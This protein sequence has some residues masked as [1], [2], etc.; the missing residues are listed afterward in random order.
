MTDDIDCIAVLRQV[1]ALV[2]PPH[3]WKIA[4]QLTYRI[5]IQSE[6]NQAGST[7]FSDKVY[8]CAI[9]RINNT[10]LNSKREIKVC[11][12]AFYWGTSSIVK[13][14]SIVNAAGTKS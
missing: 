5:S 9:R 7:L 4:Y 1:Y 11:S 13:F 2:E 10:G 14:E 6:W 3:L 8:G 12:K